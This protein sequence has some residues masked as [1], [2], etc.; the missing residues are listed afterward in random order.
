MAL[1]KATLLIGHSHT[2]FGSELEKAGQKLFKYKFGGV[3]SADTLPKNLDP[4]K[5][6]I[7]NVDDS[8]QEGSHWV[9]IFDSYIY[10]SFGRSAREMNPN[11][12]G[13]GLKKTEDDI[14]QT[15]VQQNCGQRSLGFLIV[16]KSHGI[17][18]AKL[19]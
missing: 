16:C 4:K 9:A 6:F 1:K 2:T 14:E 12:V 7:C 3:Y 11:F 15:A 18:V 13:H 19:I 8:T 5:Y 17:Q 10:D